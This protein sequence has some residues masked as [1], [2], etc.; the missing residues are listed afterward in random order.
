MPRVSLIVPAY[1]TLA[2]LP[3][4]VESL[5]GQTFTDFELLI[6]DDGSTD[7]TAEWV[8]AQSDS[9]IRLVRQLNRGLAGA[10]NGG[11]AEAQGEYLGFCDG[12]DLWEP[13]KLETHIAYL[14]Q[15][16]TVGMTYSGSVLID[17]NGAS[18]GMWQ[19]PKKGV[20]TPRDIL[21]RNPIGNGS[22]PVIRRQALDDVAFRPAGE[23][24][25]WWF[26]ETFR[27]SEDIECW[28]RIAL[29]TRWEISG[30]S[31]PLTKYRIVSSGLSANLI[32]Q[33][34]SWCRVASRIIEIE[35]SFARANL[36]AA[37]AYQLRYLARRAVTLSDGQSA[38]RLMLD[39][40]KSSLRPFVH[41]PVKTLTTLAAAIVLSLGG[42]RIIKMALSG[43]Q[44]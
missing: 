31:D 18:M 36:P 29:T 13:T 33:Y 14:D 4:T 7:G 9:R 44:T 40:A 25:D 35:P 24:R 37:R 43:R 42:Q 10:R 17:I 28:M 5:L 41:E 30:V 27:Q 16:N 12:D 3:E 38:L 6:V 20:V 39:S 19:K 34:E 11:I 26:D 15:N 2:S 32:K 21:L 22:S 1:N 23:S 8:L